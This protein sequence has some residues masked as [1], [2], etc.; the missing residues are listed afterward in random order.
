MFGTSVLVCAAGLAYGCLAGSSSS[1]APHSDEQPPA[2]EVVSA[3]NDLPETSSQE[4]T[5]VKRADPPPPEESCD[6]LRVLVDRRHD[7]PP[8]YQP[9]DL[10]SLQ[11]LGVPTSGGDQFLRREAARHLQSLVSEA[12]RDNVE[13]LAASAYRSYADQQ[14]THA[15]WAGYYGDANAG[16]MSAQPG[17]SQ[18]QLGTAVDFTN[19]DAGYSIWQ[20]FGDT[21]AS[22]W[23]QQNA[24]DH[25]YVLA[26]PRGGEKETGYGWEPWHYRYIGMENTGRM[27]ESDLGLQEFLTREGVMPRC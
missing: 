22:D 23:L 10:V 2:R 24:P 20:G 19:A 9:S 17:Q 15:S 6:D 18:H 13:L 7:L 11:A 26:Y 27:K 12:A 5:T 3:S 21:R 8:G 25:G 4:E 1:W 16:G 14:S